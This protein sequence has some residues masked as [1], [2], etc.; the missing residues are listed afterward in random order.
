MYVYALAKNQVLVRFT[1]MED[2]FDDI[3]HHGDS[4][5]SSLAT[6]SYTLD[7]MQYATLLYKQANHI[8]LMEQDEA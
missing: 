3:K 8:S 7:I 2:R 6:K 4:N 5:R 1:N